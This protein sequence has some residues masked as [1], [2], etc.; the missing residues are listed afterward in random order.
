MDH[1]SLTFNGGC[2]LHGVLCSVKMEKSMFFQKSIQLSEKIKIKIGIDHKIEND[3]IFFEEELKIMVFDGNENVKSVSLGGCFG[4]NKFF[5]LIQ[6]LSVKEIENHPI[7]IA[8]LTLIYKDDNYYLHREKFPDVLLDSSAI[9]RL[10]TITPI[11]T[12]RRVQYSAEKVDVF[13]NYI[14]SKHGLDLLENEKI[15]IDEE[16]VFI[17]ELMIEISL[18]FKNLYTFYVNL[19][20]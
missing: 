8:D 6:T 20:H 13:F 18:H 12:F 15:I 3:S 14:A 9:E 11:L 4:I 10:K 7:D 16:D 19:N 5:Q 17:K 2:H 1:I